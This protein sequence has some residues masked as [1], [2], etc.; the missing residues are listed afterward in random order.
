MGVAS[1]YF[2]YASPNSFLFLNNIAKIDTDAELHSFVFGQ[3]LVAFGQIPL[4]LHRT[5]HRIHHT[6]KL[7]QQIVS[8]RIH[9]LAAVQQDMIGHR[10]PVRGQSADRT[11]LICAHQAAV[12][13]HIGTEDSSQFSFDFFRGRNFY[14]STRIIIAAVIFPQ[15]E[16]HPYTIRPNRL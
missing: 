10:I 4:N 15:R 12:A 5:L 14:S 11:Q 3:F 13:F 1:L 9:H 2:N 7:R 16:N 8:G 6:D